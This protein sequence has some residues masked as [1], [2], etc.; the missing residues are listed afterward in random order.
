LPAPLAGTTI[1][2]VS[3][4]AG[5]VVVPGSFAERAPIRY[6]KPPVSGVPSVVI[7]GVPL[8]AVVPSVVI[9]GDSDGRMFASNPAVVVRPQPAGVAVPVPPTSKLPLIGVCGFAAFAPLAVMSK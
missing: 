8:P 2:L 4:T 9:D 5:K 3:V 6:E 1:V 7:G